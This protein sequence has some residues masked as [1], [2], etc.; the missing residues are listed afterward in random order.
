MLSYLIRVF[1]GGS[2]NGVVGIGT[3]D[4]EGI[5]AGGAGVMLCYVIIY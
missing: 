1:G 2:E 4:S 3:W 5:G